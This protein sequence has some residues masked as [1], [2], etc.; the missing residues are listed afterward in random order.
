[1]LQQSGMYEVSRGAT[2]PHTKIVH[3]DAVATQVC[4]T[5]TVHATK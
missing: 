4:I 3:T 1:M 5:Y 2:M